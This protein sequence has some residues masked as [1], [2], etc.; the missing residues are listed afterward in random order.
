MGA[1]RVWARGVDANSE[2]ARLSVE[3]GKVDALWFPSGCETNDPICGSVAVC[4]SGE[5]DVRYPVCEGCVVNGGGV[6]VALST[7]QFESET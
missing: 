4:M 7:Q 5:E 6:S 2:V 3:S 1:R